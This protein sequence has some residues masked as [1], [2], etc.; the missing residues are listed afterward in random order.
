MIKSALSI[1]IR[2]Y[3]TSNL[4]EACFVCYLKINN[5]FANNNAC[6]KLS[7]KLKM[8]LKC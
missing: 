6:S 5:T 1:R 8:A 4:K 7:K 2:G 3:C